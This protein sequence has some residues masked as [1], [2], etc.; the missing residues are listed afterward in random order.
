MHAKHINLSQM[1]NRLLW[2]GTSLFGSTTSL[3]RRITV[4]PLSDTVW[5]IDGTPHIGSHLVLQSQPV[6]ISIVPR[7]YD[8]GIFPTSNLRLH[9]VAHL[10]PQIL[11]RSTQQEITLE[12][13]RFISLP[14]NTHRHSRPSPPCVPR[15]TPDPP[16]TSDAKPTRKTT[17]ELP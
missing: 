4:P 1:R 7:L 9:L 6:A 12:V 2:C 11:L 13:L 14:M 15:A 17:C 3:R 16:I 10:E 8:G 5:Q